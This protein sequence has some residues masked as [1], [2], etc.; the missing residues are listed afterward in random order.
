MRFLYTF[1]YEKQEKAAVLSKTAAFAEILK[2]RKFR[3][4]RPDRAEAPS[5]G[6]RPGLSWTQTW[7]PVR[8]KALKYRA[9]YKAFAPTGR[10]ADCYY[11]QGDAL[12]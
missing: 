8:A 4:T 9:I 10:L 12:G 7:R 1:A 11:T 6:R 5:P 2:F 3:P